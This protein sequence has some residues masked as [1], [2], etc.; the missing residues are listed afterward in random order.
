MH[1]NLHKSKVTSF[2]ST[3]LSDEWAYLQLNCPAYSSATRTTQQ[4]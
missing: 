1:L 4:F 3:V 2:F